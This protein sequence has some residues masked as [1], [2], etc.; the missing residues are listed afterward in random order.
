MEEG[1]SRINVIN[2]TYHNTAGFP[3][4]I[5]REICYLQFRFLCEMI[6]LGC[7]VIHGDIKKAGALR[8]E[9]QPSKI[10]RQL[11]SLKVYFYPQPIEIKV[12]DG[13]HVQHIARPDLPHLSKSEL[14][15][16]WRVAGNFLHR[17]KLLN[18]G[19]GEDIVRSLKPIESTPDNFPDIFQWTE[20]IV[21]LLNC[22]WITLTE[23]KRGMVVSLLSPEENRAKAS[24][25]DYNLT[26]ASKPI[27]SVESF[28]FESE[29]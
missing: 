18:L 2:H 11:E 14:S 1:R 16:L 3:S 17:G 22:H 9:Y 26:D 6:A 4:Q 19:A 15:E 5:V 21:G 29:R 8:K 23:N 24:I 10:L 27:A 28:N 12:M 25:L 20:K 7:L 13:G